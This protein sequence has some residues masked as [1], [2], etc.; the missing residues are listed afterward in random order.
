M[1]VIVWSSVD[2][3]VFF[4]GEGLPFRSLPF[5]NSGSTFKTAFSGILGR[6][7]MGWLAIQAWYGNEL[8][9][10][11]WVTRGGLW[12]VDAPFWTAPTVHQILVTLGGLGS[13]NLGTA[14]MLPKT[15]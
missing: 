14:T 15:F 6:T 12:S 11:Y 9:G 2:V 8:F 10:V 5:E 1:L 7:M 13:L 3:Q 4:E